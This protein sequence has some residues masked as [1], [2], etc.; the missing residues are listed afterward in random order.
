MG[1]GDHRLVRGP[2]GGGADLFDAAAKAD[3]ELRLRTLERPGIGRLQ[4]GLGR[5]D[6]APIDE[7]LPEQPVFIADAIAMCGNFE[8]RHGFEETGRQPTQ[9]AVAQRR[10]GFVMQQRTQ[11]DSQFAGHRLHPLGQPQIG[12]RVFQQP[13]EQELHRQIVDPLGVGVIGRPDRFEP[14]VHDLVADRIRQRHPPVVKLGVGGVLGQRV[15]QMA[16]HRVAQMLGRHGQVVRHVGRACLVP[17]ASIGRPARG[18][19]R[20]ACNL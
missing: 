5:F 11:L 9:P 4:P 3:L 12:D 18:G 20:L 1:L 19:K 10:I 13:T 6:L 16:Q 17:G 2:A 8:R 15:G 7:A 14:A